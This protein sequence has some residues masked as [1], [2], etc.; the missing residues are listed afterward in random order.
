MPIGTL[1]GLSKRVD[2]SDLAD[3]L[4]LNTGGSGVAGGV[5]GGVPGG[6]VGGVVGSTGPAVVG[7]VANVAPPPPPPK[8]EPVR[9]GGQVLTSRLINHPSPIYPPLARA[10]RVQGTVILQVVV[11]ESG[12][13]RETKIISGHPLLTQAAVDAVQQWVYS[14][15]LLNGEPIP[16]IGTVTVRFTLGVQ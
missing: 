9:V 7:G 10:A 3:L 8:K 6:V 12:R 13:V 2:K 16:V 1:T 11:D 5:P 14:P 4:G 15:T